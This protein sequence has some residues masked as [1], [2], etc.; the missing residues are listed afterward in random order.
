MKLCAVSTKVEDQLQVVWIVMGDYKG[1]ADT[2]G[3]SAGGNA[4]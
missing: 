3:S 4:Y 2:R 1:A